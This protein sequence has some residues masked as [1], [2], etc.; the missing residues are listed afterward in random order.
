MLSTKRERRKRG[1]D[2]NCVCNYETP[3]WLC[4]MHGTAKWIIVLGVNNAR[5]ERSFWVKSSPNTSVR[6]ENLDQECKRTC[7]YSTELP[8]NVRKLFKSFFF[9][10]PCVVL[11]ID[12]RCVYTSYNNQNSFSSLS[13]WPLM[14]FESACTIYLCYIGCW[15]I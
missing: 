5:G 2:E 8:Q 13:W 11:F 3:L 1:R 15:L 10:S 7:K 14:N 12:I 4:W 6:Y 9:F